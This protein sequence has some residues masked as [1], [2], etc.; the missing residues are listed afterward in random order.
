MSFMDDAMEVEQNDGKLQEVHQF[1]ILN[2]KNWETLE[3]RWLS[4]IC[5]ILNF[6]LSWRIN[7]RGSK[8]EKQGI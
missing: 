5:L 6:E 1:D 8:K 4:T 2:R 7:A 3:H